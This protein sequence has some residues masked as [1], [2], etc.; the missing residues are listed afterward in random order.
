M[1]PHAIE[2]FQVPFDGASLRG[3]VLGGA[4]PDLALML[5]GAGQHHRGKMRALRDELAARGVG[6]CAV[7]LIGHGETGGE[8]RESSLELR[9]R[10]VCA[11][12][13]ALGLCA[14]G[15][16]A[17][18]AAS[19]GAHTAVDLLDHYPVGRLVLVVPAMYASAAQEVPFGAGFTE[20]IRRPQSWRQA[21]GWELLEGFTGCLL[22]IAGAEDKVIPRGVIERYRRGAPNAHRSEV[23]EVPNAGHLLFS[24]LR[25]RNP[26]A[27]PP[28]VDAMA[29]ALR[30]PR[31]PDAEPGAEPGA[32]P[33]AQM[34]ASTAR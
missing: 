25:E 33:D 26:E 2:P 6:T 5:H 27:V 34:D 13:D 10:Q 31:N 15:A 4:L 14:R 30:S 9:T 32:E 22:V 16:L 24:E 8:L 28:L 7:D 17:V 23:I 1:P 29:D 11:V 20:I 12:I 3:D 18:T 19:M 21:R